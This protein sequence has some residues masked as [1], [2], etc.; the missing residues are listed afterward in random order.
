MTKGWFFRRMKLKVIGCGVFA[1]YLELLRK[2]SPHDLEFELLEAGLHDTP[3]LLRSLLQNAIDAASASGKYDAVVLLYGL[4]G[5]GTAELQAR[6]IP[7]VIPRAH[8]CTTLFLGSHKAFKEQFLK[9]PGTLYHTLGWLEQKLNP[10]N[11]EAGEL[12][13]NYEQAGYQAHPEFQSLAERYGEENAEHILAFFERWRDHYTRAVFLECGLEQEDT[14]RR[15]TREMAEVFGW[16]F[17]CLPIDFTLL[18]AAVSGE[19]NTETCVVVPPGR[20][21]RSTGDDRI[22]EA[23]PLERE[24]APEAIL[25]EEDPRKPTSPQGLGLGLD[26]GG[27]YTDAV[28]YDFSTGEVLAKSKA[29]TTYHDLVK[30]I[31]GALAGLPDELLRQVQL[32][33]LSTTLATNAIVEDRGYKVG[34]LVLAPWQSFLEQIGHSPARWVPGHVTITGEVGRELDEEA[35]RKAIGELLN[36]GCAALVIAAYGAV[37]NPSQVLRVREL[38]AELTDVPILCSHELTRRLNAVNAAHTAIANARLM[39][40]LAE[41]L[42]S[43][44]RAL[45]DFEVSGRLLVVKGDGTPV[46]ESVARARPIETLLSGPAASVSGARLLTGLEKALVVDIGGTTTDCAV[47][48]GGRVA[49]SARGARVGK[50]TFSLDVVEVVTTGL[51]GDSRLDFDRERK[52]T[53]GPRRNVPLCCLAAE[54]ERV[55]HFLETF[56]YERFA[57]WTSAAPLD[58]L[59]RGSRPR[60]KPTGSEARLLSLLEQGPI[61]ALEAA[62]RLGLDS[63]ILLPLRRLEAQGAVKRGALTPTDLLHVQGVFTRWDKEAAGLALEAFSAMFGRSPEETLKIGLEAVHKRLFE[64]VLQRAVSHEAPQL[65]S[66]PEDWRFLLDKAF[67][68][69]GAGLQV[70]LKLDR[71]VVA[72]GAPAEALASP[73]AEALGQEIIV[74][75]HAEVANA[76]GAIGT[77]IV[78]SEELLIR[79]ALKSGYL[80]HGREECMEFEELETATQEALQRARARALEGALKAGAYAPSLRVVRFDRTS[81]LADG[82]RLWL[83]RRVVAVA[84]GPASCAEARAGGRADG[85]LASGAQN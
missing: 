21:T 79:P 11:R 26:A 73:L 3:G 43:V 14:A 39:P 75:D 56:D 41:L 17:E 72:L 48:E 46:A 24:A 28:I 55:K 74:P 67:A 68:G 7:L 16:Q 76:V 15:F 53:V 82:S 70:Q 47:L 58:V 32:T 54:S 63:P 84:S 10:R 19:W 64:V 65:S 78:V 40:V 61:S 50:R 5:R 52:I 77:E 45:V 44:H 13:V 37:R 6:E 57:G 60:L 35:C 22:L 2:R 36:E 12:Y 8:D 31:R 34:L 71:P 29:L 1:P 27:T 80:L 62:E 9:A 33:A 42:D 49:I 83:E 66:L 85:E 25:L 59:V 23:L 30:G 4:C 69:R 38:A 18:E 51:G 20:R 81:T